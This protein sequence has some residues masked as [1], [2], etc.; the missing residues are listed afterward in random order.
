MEIKER[1]SL[2]IEDKYFFSVIV[3]YDQNKDIVEKVTSFYK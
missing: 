1:S 2:V 3:K